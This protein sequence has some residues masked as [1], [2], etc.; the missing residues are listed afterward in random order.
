[1]LSVDPR[2]FFPT[3]AGDDASTL[4][5]VEVVYSL[6]AEDLALGGTGL[7]GSEAEALCGSN[8]AGGGG[9]AL[10]GV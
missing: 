10:D 6:G 5:R 2:T 1:M 4:R 7:S 8:G 9:G 3:W